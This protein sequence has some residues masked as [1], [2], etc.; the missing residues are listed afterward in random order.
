MFFYTHTC[1]THN[2]LPQ[3]FTTDGLSHK[4]HV[5]CFMNTLRL[6]P[7][8][9]DLWCAMDDMLLWYICNIKNPTNIRGTGTGIQIDEQLIK[10]LINVILY[11]I[12]LQRHCVLQQL[13]LIAV[14]LILIRAKLRP[15]E[16]VYY[17][18]WVQ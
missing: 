4:S 15:M 17:R 10:G 13:F 7:H 1:T 3:Y 9:Y 5:C 8:T 16:S 18:N 2:L 12:P 6:C 11:H 14:I